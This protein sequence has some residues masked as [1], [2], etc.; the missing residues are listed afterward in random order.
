M[1]AIVFRFDVEAAPEAV[2]E[3]LTTADGIK[4]FWTT[5]ADVPRE[6]GETLKLGFSV[7]RPHLLTSGSSSPT[8]T[9]SRGE[10][11]RSRRTGSARPSAGTSKRAM[12]AHRSASGT[13]A[14]ATTPPPATPPSPGAR[15]W[16]DSSTTPKPATQRPSSPS[17]HACRRPDAD[18][19][20]PAAR[21]SGG[22]RGRPGQRDRVV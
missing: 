12:T 19:D 17:A 13:T 11:R 22:L 3:A 5:R 9:P 1:T 20:S 8:T 21:R 6:V 14:S 18:H 15:S 10:P 2:L 7:A 4:S 16:C